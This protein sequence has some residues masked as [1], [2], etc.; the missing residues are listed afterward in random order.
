MFVNYA[1]QIGD[2]IDRNKSCVKCSE[3]KS[4]ISREEL[5]QLISSDVSEEIED[6]YELRILNYYIDS[7]ELCNEDV[8][9]FEDYGITNNIFILIKLIDNKEKVISDSEEIKCVESSIMKLNNNIL[10]NTVNL[11]EYHDN[12]SSIFAQ[13]SNNLYN[14]NINLFFVYFNSLSFDEE[15]NQS[16]NYL[17]DFEPEIKKFS[18]FFENLNKKIKVSFE[19]ANQSNFSQI[20]K[21]KPNIIFISCIG[22]FRLIDNK[23]EFSICLEDD[24]GQLSVISLECFKILTNNNNV[25]LIIV[26]TNY[27]KSVQEFFVQAGF[28]NVI[29]VYSKYHTLDRAGMNFLKS[30][31]KYL[32]DGN[33]LSDSFEFSKKIITKKEKNYRECI[34]CCC[35]HEY[36]RSNNKQCNL[37]KKLIEYDKYYFC[38]LHNVN[39]KRYNKKN[40]CTCN[41]KEFKHS[42]EEKFMMKFQ[43]NLIIKNVEDGKPEI[44]TT[45]SFEKLRLGLNLKN[46]IFLGRNEKILDIC[47]I[48]S[49][50]PNKRIYNLTGERGSGKKTIVKLVA[51]FYSMRSKYKNIVYIESN[52]IYTLLYI[53]CCFEN[54]LNFCLDSEDELFQKISDMNLIIII[55]V[56]NLNKNDK[57]DKFIDNFF[58]NYLVLFH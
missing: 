58:Y 20:L 56:N 27:S 23:P 3:K 21:Q 47:N 44:F 57:I 1:F 42:L 4:Q 15:S 8:I 45:K 6:I 33:S 51:K 28:S 31:Y 5:I 48:L 29:C 10:K 50:N 41:I 7:F 2:S 43:E 38:S 32:L 46:N 9:Y 30:F 19:I 26:S 55:V 12:V 53:K 37:M 11:Y 35:Y 49:S 39:E 14:N 52:I 40:S 17:V 25:D 36:V 18:K 16:L 54:Q 34:P 22:I 13:S 24:Y